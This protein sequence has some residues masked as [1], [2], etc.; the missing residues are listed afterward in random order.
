VLSEIEAKSKSRAA[1]VEFEFE[2]SS[3]LNCGTAELMLCSFE[4]GKVFALL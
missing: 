1:F 3:K 4:F 2:L